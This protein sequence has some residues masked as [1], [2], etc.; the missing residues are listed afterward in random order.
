MLPTG[1]GPIA[2]SL[3]STA[4]PPAATTASRTPWPAQ[5]AV[6]TPIGQ[7]QLGCFDAPPHWDFRVAI[8]CK[9]LVENNDSGCRW[10]L[11]SCYSRYC[12]NVA[13]D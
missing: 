9:K 2:S 5:R 3:K 13:T 11:V 1:Y 10:F 7:R 4:R 12:G 6:G 8:D